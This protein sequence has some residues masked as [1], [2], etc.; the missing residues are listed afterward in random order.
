MRALQARHHG[1]RQYGGDV[2]GG[3]LRFL[4]RVGGRGDGE[5]GAC[6]QYGSTARGGAAVGRRK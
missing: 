2:D 6:E 4:A 5:R 3:L 1:R